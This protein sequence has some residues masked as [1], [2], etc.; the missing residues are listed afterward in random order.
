MAATPEQHRAAAGW[1]GFWGRRGIGPDDPLATLREVLARHLITGRV[2]RPS[3]ST[4]AA[5]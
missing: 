4:G 1:R 5:A 3:A 2:E